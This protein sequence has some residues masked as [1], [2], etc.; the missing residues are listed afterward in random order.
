MLFMKN[1]IKRRDVSGISEFSINR[2][3]PFLKEAVEQIQSNIVK[4]YKNTSGTSR[5]AILQAINS[6]GEVMGHTSFIQQIEVD[7]QQFTKIY[8]SQFSAFFELKPQ[9]IRVFGYIMKQLIPKKDEFIF[10]LEDCMEYTKYN[11]E[12]SIRIG[13]TSLLKANIIARGR[14][15]VLY[16]INPMVAF[17]GDRVTFAKTYVKKQNEKKLDPNQITLSLE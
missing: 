8:L 17:N 10:I 7:D 4:R 9:A 2:E 3:N 1:K 14:A 15:D 11:S 13:L 12:T 16:F 6:D 5:N